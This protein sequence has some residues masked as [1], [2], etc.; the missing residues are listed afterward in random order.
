MPGRRV[1]LVDRQLQRPG[2]VLVG[3]L[4]EADVAVA[5]L[6]EAEACCQRGLRYRCVGGGGKESGRGH[7]ARHRP[8]KAGARPGHA[9]E[10]ISPVDAVVG[11]GHGLC[12][13]GVV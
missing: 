6:H 2:D 5:D 7:A 12:R 13:L 4:V 11:A 9:A 10:K 8:Q 3:R 1:D